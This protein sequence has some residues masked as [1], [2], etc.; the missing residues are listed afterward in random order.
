MSKK[1]MTNKQMDLSSGP[2]ESGKNLKKKIVIS[3]VKKDPLDQISTKA[4]NEVDFIKQISGRLQDSKRCQD[5]QYLKLA[6]NKEFICTNFEALW[7]H[8]D[9]QFAQFENCSYQKEKEKKLISQT[10]N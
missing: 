9:T 6:E 10:F 3:S 7:Y 1:S 8:R 4:K 5:C 2:A